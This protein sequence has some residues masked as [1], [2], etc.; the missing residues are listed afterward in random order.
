MH[1]TYHVDVD[2]DDDDDVD[3]DVV[4]WKLNQV[5]RSSHLNVIPNPPRALT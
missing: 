5:I 2:V 1:T 3:V 4:N